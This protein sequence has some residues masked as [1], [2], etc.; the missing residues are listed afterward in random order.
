MLSQSKGQA[1]V[2]RSLEKL[3][4]QSL[5]RAVHSGLDDYRRT[6]GGRVVLFKFAG[7]GDAPLKAFT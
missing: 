1:A 5:A 4:R 6:A 2:V 3:G 7:N